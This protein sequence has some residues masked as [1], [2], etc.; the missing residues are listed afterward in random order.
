MLVGSLIAGIGESLIA[1]GSIDIG[2]K[3]Y[4]IG[5]AVVF[6]GGLIG[7][8]YFWLEPIL[9]WLAE[10]SISKNTK[11]KILKYFEN[12]IVKIAE[13]LQLILQKTLIASPSYSLFS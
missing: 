13:F 5:V 3:V 10:Q 6:F 9:E 4:L 1:M 2:S 8:G 11:P 12:L 7:F